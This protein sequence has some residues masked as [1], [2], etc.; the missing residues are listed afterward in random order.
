MTENNAHH[1]YMY[2]SD[3][4][5]TYFGYR[6]ALREISE[7]LGTS[8]WISTQLWQGLCTTRTIQNP[9]N[10]GFIY[11][12]K[13]RSAHMDANQNPE[14]ITVAFTDLK[15]GT[16]VKSVQFFCFQW[17]VFQGTIDLT[18]SRKY[19]HCSISFKDLSRGL[20]WKY[21]TDF[22]LS[23]EVCWTVT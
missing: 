3:P 21:G 23:E 6:L 16:A 19:L 4:T 10:V 5:E 17:I 20:A 2:N 7:N 18:A 9:K 14:T 11:A 15:T 22:K 12:T 1:A 8:C 13:T